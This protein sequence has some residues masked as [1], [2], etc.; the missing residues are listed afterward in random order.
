MAAFVIV[1]MEIDDA[2]T[3]ADYRAKA[4][5][6]IERHGGRYLARGGATEVIEGDWSPSRVVLLEFPDVA[7]A[8][9]FFADPDY[10]AIADI[11]HRAARSQIVIVEGVT[12]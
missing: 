6:F 3:F 9:A 5:A 1:T 10:V 2:D 7:S 12:A 4:P 8:Q 11:R